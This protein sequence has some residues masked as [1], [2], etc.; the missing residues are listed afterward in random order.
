M[1]RVL[2]CLRFEGIASRILVAIR[3]L[4]RRVVS[5]VDPR[6]SMRRFW[7]G[8]TGTTAV[9]RTMSLTYPVLAFDH[10]GSGMAVGWASFMLSLPGFLF[11]LPFGAMIDRQDPSQLM[12]RVEV[13]RLLT[14]LFVGFLLIA[15]QLTLPIILAAAFLEGT[16]WIAY[17]LAESALIPSLVRGPAKLTLFLASSERS[18]QIG[19]LIARP[20]AG[21][22]YAWHSAAPFLIA[23]A[24]ALVSALTV[25]RPRVV[26]PRRSAEQESM[27][28]SIAEGLRELNRHP[29][30][31]VAVILTTTTNFM[32][33]VLIVVFIAGY[34]PILGVTEVG[35]YLAF[36]GLG[37]TLGT[38][39]ARRIRPETWVLHTQV[40]MVAVAMFAITC[41]PHPVS[42]ALG[43]LL[44]GW[45]TAT[46][47]AMRRYE[48]AFVV[49]QKRA[50]VASVSRL[51]GHTAVTAAAPLGG[52]LVTVYGVEGAAH[53]LAYGFAVIGGLIVMWIVWLNSEMTGDHGIHGLRHARGLGGR[54]RLLRVFGQNDRSGM[55]ARFL[56]PH[57]TQDR[58]PMYCR[59]GGDRHD[60]VF[61][62]AAAAYRAKGPRLGDIGQERTF[63]TEPLDAPRRFLWPAEIGAD[64]H[65]LQGDWRGAAPSVK[66]AGSVA[67]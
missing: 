46:N 49:R 25:P 55:T 31:L 61:R 22:L 7:V 28:V 26:R 35:V 51:L 48:G 19:S 1:S 3:G 42:F 44:T 67:G 57:L 16:M 34:V 58:W 30:L 60:F 9:A 56:D 13:V 23:P 66:Q 14:L 4:N 39:V 59:D 33:N 20:L 47:I 15:G 45:G 5:A 63:R 12:R 21:C 62:F 43:L 27:W 36:G 53:L 54:G 64:V 52:V 38:I 8:L 40:V 17:S 11:Y 10:S 2:L 37:G 29:F 6:W 32:V 50:R 65:A 24:F 18:T 41:Y